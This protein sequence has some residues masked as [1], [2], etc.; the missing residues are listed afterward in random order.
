[1]YDACGMLTPT[2]AELSVHYISGDF[3]VSSECAVTRRMSELMSRGLKVVC[4]QRCLSPS[5]EIPPHD[6]PPHRSPPHQSPPH[7]NPPHHSPPPSQSIS[8]SKA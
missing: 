7:Q 3:V 2:D 5:H 8:S 4:S 6:S 1:M